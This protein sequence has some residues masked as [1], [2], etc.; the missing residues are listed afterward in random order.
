MQICYKVFDCDGTK[1]K[2]LLINIIPKDTGNH[3]NTL[4]NKEFKIYLT[5]EVFADT[6]WVIRIRNSKDR[7]HNNQKKKDKRTNNDLQN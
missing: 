4:K 6:K 3:S 7:Q 1:T 2:W 5:E